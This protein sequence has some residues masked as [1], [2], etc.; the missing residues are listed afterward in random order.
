Q[1]AVETIGA[2]RNIQIKNKKQ[3]AEFF[4]RQQE[5]YVEAKIQEQLSNEAFTNTF[6]KIFKNYFSKLNDKDA[7]FASTAF[8]SR[9]GIEQLKMQFEEIVQGFTHKDSLTLDEAIR[10]CR[11]YELFEI[12]KAIEPLAIVLL[13]EEE[14]IRYIIQDSILIT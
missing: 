9:N 10:L 5:L 3:N 2:L 11:S 13:K 14:N 1:S 12:M 8:L 7:A 4:Y 6:R